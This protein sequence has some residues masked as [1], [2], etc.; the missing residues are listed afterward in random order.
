MKKLLLVA[1][2]AIAANAGIFTTVATWNDLQIQP[3]ARY[4]VDIAGQ[5]TRHY[6]YTVQG[7]KPLMQCEIVFVDSTYKAPVKNCWVKQK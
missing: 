6:T 1:F 4:T 3:D 5:D 2:M 7:S